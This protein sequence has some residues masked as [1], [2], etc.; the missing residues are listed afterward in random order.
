MYIRMY[1][2]NTYKNAILHTIKIHIV[3]NMAVLYI[4]I[5]KYYTCTHTHA[6]THTH[7]FR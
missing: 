4:H 3:C 5:H 6:N 1:I 2:C 7:R